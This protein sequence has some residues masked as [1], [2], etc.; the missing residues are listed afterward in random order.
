MFRAKTQEN[1]WDSIVMK[2]KIKGN[3]AARILFYFHT[4]SGMLSMV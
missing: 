1:V 3:H 4:K 2:P